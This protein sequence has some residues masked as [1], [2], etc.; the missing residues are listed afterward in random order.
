ARRVSRKGWAGVEGPR[1]NVTQPNAGRAATTAAIRRTRSVARRDHRQ[2]DRGGVGGGAGGGFA[3][4]AAGG[5]APGAGVLMVRLRGANRVVR[6]FRT[7]R[8]P[9]PVGREEPAAGRW[10]SLTGRGPSGSRM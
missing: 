1:G 7:G 5:P 10:Q 9:G 8:R 4:V 6:V 3:G 2:P